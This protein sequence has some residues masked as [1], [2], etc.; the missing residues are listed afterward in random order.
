MAV[1]CGLGG[2]EG[3]DQNESLSAIISFLIL[4]RNISI[5]KSARRLPERLHGEIVAYQS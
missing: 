2:A 5:K 4:S 3:G 1:I